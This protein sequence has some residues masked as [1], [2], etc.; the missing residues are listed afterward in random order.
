MK[1]QKLLLI[2][3][4]LIGY[5]SSGVALAQWGHEL[6]F[7]FIEKDPA[8]KIEVPTPSS[9]HDSCAYQVFSYLHPDSRF[10]VS[11]PASPI[12]L[13]VK[14]NPTLKHWYMPDV[15]LMSKYFRSFS[16]TD[17]SE[18]TV[19][20]LGITRDNVK[21]YRYRVVED[22]SVEL[23]KWSAIPSLDQKYGAKQ[24]YG[25][26]GNF[27]ALNKQL[28]IEIVNVN[29]YSIREGVIFDWREISPPVVTQLS[30]LTHDP[31]K[32]HTYPDDP[33][34]K[35]PNFFNISAIKVNRG[36]ATKFDKQTNLPL[37]MKFGVDSVRGISLYFK[38]H[39]AVTYTIYVIRA[40]AG[41]SDTTMIAY[42]FG[43]NM[44]PVVNKFF[45]QPGKYQ[46]VVQLASASSWQDKGTLSIPFEVKPPPLTQKKVSIKQLI[47]YTVA[48]LCG[49][50]FLFF[51]YRRQSRAKIRRV[52][53]EKQVVGLKL[54]SIRA[55]L[56]P[57]FMFN[58]LTSIQNLIN[59]NNIA[60]ANYYLSKFAGLTRQVLDSSNDDVLSLEDELKVL[61]N[62]LQMEQLRFNFKYDIKV[63]EQL[64]QANIEIPA[65]LLQPFAEN[66]IKHG[67]SGLDDA[68]KI[69][70]AITADGNNLVLTVADNGAGFV[71]DAD[72]E[73]Y[74]IKLT[75][76]RVALLN[77]IYKDQSV[78][79]DINAT[80][81]GT[82][83]TIR[84]TNW[85]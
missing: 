67:I 48:T 69:E 79:L 71:K 50:A 18:A 32:S 41:K 38:D 8:T 56:N 52:A 60:G 72:A 61:N 26:I 16:I 2:L 63:D 81:R 28:L 15:R 27:K 14:L 49:V 22:D 21:D 46:I 51:I 5:G 20:A 1:K 40:I 62:Y 84:L 13:G 68:G 75:E 53:Q 35:H 45:N 43:D 6:Q 47:P 66:A 74:G 31:F 59:K 73:G 4:L 36:I 44:F 29:D 83:V 10:P 23:V 24:P 25:F 82:T 70:I 80:P 30:I 11:K 42:N 34:D 37:D 64:N 77:Q 17:G 7:Q 33:I 78:T 54:R 57:H 39:P 85:I 55:Q 19:I 3:W 12:I 65:M 9:F 58:A 76:E